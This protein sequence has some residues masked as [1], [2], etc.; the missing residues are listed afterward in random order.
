MTRW[1]MDPAQPEWPPRE[2]GRNGLQQPI[3]NNSPLCTHQTGT[4][5]NLSLWRSH[6][7][8]IKSSS[9]PHSGPGCL[10][11]QFLPRSEEIGSISVYI[12]R[13]ADHFHY[14]LEWNHFEWNIFFSCH[15]PSS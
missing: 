13:A 1:I 4:I 10:C 11:P 6:S 8:K 9:P 15:V 5:N 3:T 12:L 14:V 7:L 2:L